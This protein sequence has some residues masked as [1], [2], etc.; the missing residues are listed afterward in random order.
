[1]VFFCIL[2]KY[3]KIQNFGDNNINKYF[4]FSDKNIFLIV[5]EFFCGNEYKIKYWYIKKK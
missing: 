1:M 3:L 4:S 2:V 5:K